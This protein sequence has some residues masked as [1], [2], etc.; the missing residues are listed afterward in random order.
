M[1]KL[2]EIF[3]LEALIGLCALPFLIHHVRAE[4]MAKICRRFGVPQGISYQAMVF[5]PRYW[6]LWTQ[7]QW[8][9]FIENPR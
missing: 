5:N 4:Q 1:L 6:H 3:W 8:A 2:L 7:R 9:T